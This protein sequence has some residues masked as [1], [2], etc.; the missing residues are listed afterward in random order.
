MKSNS[1]IVALALACALSS[2]A[3][4]ENKAKDAKTEKPITPEQTQAKAEVHLKEKQ[5]ALTGSYIKRDIRRNGVV[6]DGPSPVFVLDRQRIETSGA[7]DLSQ[8]LIR[9]GFRH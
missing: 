7:A 4:A 8:V 9:S 5:V 1:L 2:T 3:F 6:T